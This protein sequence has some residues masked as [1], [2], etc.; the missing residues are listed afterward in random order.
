M[1]NILLVGFLF[2]TSVSFSQT[3]TLKEKQAIAELDFS[4]AEKRIVE[5]YGSAVKIELDKTSVA[6]DMDAI[7][8]ADS[9]GAQL[10]ANV[11]ARICGNE[12]GKEALQNQRITKIVIKNIRTGKATVEIK[13]GI[14]TLSEGLSSEDNYFGETDLREAIEKTL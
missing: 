2:I 3:L 8:Y 9:R 7:L 10:A 14:M 1:K 5:N 12:L 13:G 11:I 6:G 4:W